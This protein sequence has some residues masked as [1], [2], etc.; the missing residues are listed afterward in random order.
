[1]IEICAFFNNLLLVDYDRVLSEYTTILKTHF[2]RDNGESPRQKEK[3]EQKA[4]SETGKESRNTGLSRKPRPSMNQLDEENKQ[5]LEKE[6]EKAEAGSPSK[7]SCST[8]EKE[9][10]Q[11]EEAVQSVSEKLIDHLFN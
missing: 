10:Q 2:Y 5:A 7:A 9:K 11:L 4:A 1:M 3:R 6:L 8:A